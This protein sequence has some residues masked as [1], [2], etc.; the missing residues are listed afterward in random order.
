MIWLL[1]LN[2]AFG[3]QVD[4]RGSDCSTKIAKRFGW[5]A[6]ALCV[7]GTRVYVCQGSPYGPELPD[8][9]LTQLKIGRA[10]TVADV[11]R[12]CPTNVKVWDSILSSG[13][14]AAEHPALAKLAGDGR[15]CF[16]DHQGKRVLSLCAKSGEAF[17]AL[18]D[19][20]PE[21]VRTGLNETCGYRTE[22]VCGCGTRTDVVACLRD[23][24]LGR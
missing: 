22:E 3:L 6:D 5:V 4:V 10:D 24:L 23:R 19:Y 8:H 9:F 11:R 2:L 1:L 17:T 15:T 16:C 12:L 13:C 20:T 18:I 21:R 14:V 7:D